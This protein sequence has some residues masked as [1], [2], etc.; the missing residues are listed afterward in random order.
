MKRQIEELKV[1]NDGMKMQLA[2][3][4]DQ[5]YET[6]RGASIKKVYVCE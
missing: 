2:I 5:E 1:E 3:V 4:V 6:E